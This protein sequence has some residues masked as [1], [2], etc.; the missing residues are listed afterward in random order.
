MSH[1]ALFTPE[2][3]VENR[4]FRRT[5]KNDT[6]IEGRFEITAI[7]NPLF[8]ELTEFASN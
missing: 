1:P 4:A 3:P 6:D 7:T 8:D 2:S 5:S